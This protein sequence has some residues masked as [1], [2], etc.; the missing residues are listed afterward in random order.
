[1]MVIK[2]KDSK[3]SRDDS[4]VE[5]DV[6]V[7][8]AAMA[9]MDVAVEATTSTE[10]DTTTT[11]S[12]WVSVASATVD[13]DAA[14]AATTTTTATA[15][16]VRTSATT[17][18][19]AAA[20]VTSAATNPPKATDIVETNNE[21]AGRR[22]RHSTYRCMSLSEWA[23]FLRAAHRKTEAPGLHELSSVVLATVAQGGPRD[24]VSTIV[25][26]LERFYNPLAGVVWL[27]VRELH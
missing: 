4:M 9:A 3:I 2:E 15:T 11:G 6:V 16:T 13:S 8:A 27:N 23:L 22:R 25:S 24:S 19:T 12:V 14:A 5:M 26:P 21:T 7:T 1:M 10:L 18:S 20:A 17:V